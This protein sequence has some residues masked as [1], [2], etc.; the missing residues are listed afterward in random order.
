MLNRIK[1]RIK[2]FVRNEIVD[3]IKANSLAVRYNDAFQG[4]RGL[5]EGKDIYIVGCGPTEKYFNPIIDENRVYIG[6]NRAYLDN[7]Y[8]FNYLFAQDQMEEGMSGFLTYRDSECVKFLAIIPH[9]EADYRI[10]DCCSS[11]KT[12]IRYAL[13]GK[14]MGK[15]P[16]DISVEPVADLCGTVFSA[17]QFALF[18]NPR[19]I[20]LIGFD[21]SEGNSFKKTNASYN[22]Q[23]DGWLSIKKHLESLKKQDLVVS[24][25]PIGLKGY[26][27]DVYTRNFVSENEF[28]TTEYSLYE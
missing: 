23:L 15:I 12:A 19:R 20:Y 4:Y 3:V 16:M 25:N 27:N 11:M 24:V 22:Y 9:E 1:N 8:S 26:F 6:V 17:L 10:S 5:Y 18:T 28:D 13:A 14:R 21:C 7:K 2:Q